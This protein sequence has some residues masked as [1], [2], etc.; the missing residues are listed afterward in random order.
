MLKNDH[1]FEELCG[2]KNLEGSDGFLN[3]LC[4]AI[5][6][7]LDIICHITAALLHRRQQGRCEHW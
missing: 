6:A 5:F 2:T 3:D 1:V 7:V 4:V